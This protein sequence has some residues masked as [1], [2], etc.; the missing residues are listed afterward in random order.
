MFYT[1]LFACVLTLF[2]IALA[3]RVVYLRNILRVSVGVGDH[4]ILQRAVRVHGN[5]AEYAPLFLILCLLAEMQEVASIVVV[6]A[7][8]LFVAGRLAH[9]VGLGTRGDIMPLRVAGMVATFGA[10]VI[11]VI[12]LLIS[13]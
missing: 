2:Y 12:G 7:G 1:P 6:G 5:F 10:L 11:L 13:L 4:E 8:L 9:V 3:V